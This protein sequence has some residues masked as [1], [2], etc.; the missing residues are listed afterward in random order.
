M[1]GRSS[2]RERGGLAA[3]ACFAAVVGACGKKAAEPSKPEADP[4]EVGKLAAKM[5]RDIPTPAA[6]RECTE[7]ELRGGVT[8]TYRTL[9]ALAG[10]R[11]AETAELASWINTP[12]LESPEIHTLADDKAEDKARRQAA[13]QALA[14]PFWVVY[15]V[16]HVN[17]PLALGVKELKIGTVG[18]RVIRY[19]PT[20]A[21][22]CV[23]VFFFQ[24]DKAVSDDAIAR[25]D[26]ATVD[27]EI[28]RA[29]REDLA[30]RFAKLAPR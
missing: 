5:A 2:R 28:A 23:L 24:N 7:A 14:A 13:A 11:I 8:V 17:A 25:T 4:A 10:T 27:P 12:A 19:E 22:A 16:D 29:L 1:R 21:P 30:D 6:L 20:G 18:T 26:K 3:A 15:K 9:L